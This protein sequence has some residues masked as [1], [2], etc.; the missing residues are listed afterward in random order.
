MRHNGCLD[1]LRAAIELL[2]GTGTARSNGVAIRHDLTTYH[3]RVTR[4][5]KRGGII[6]KLVGFLVPYGRLF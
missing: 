4:V 6:N 5:C 3:T 1:D 2:D